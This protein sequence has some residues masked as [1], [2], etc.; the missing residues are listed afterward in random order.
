MPAWLA[1]RFHAL[2]AFAF[3]FAALTSPHHPTQAYK[4]ATNQIV[5][6]ADDTVPR[7]LTASTQLD[8][9]TIAGTARPA[10]RA[11]P[12]SPLESPRVPFSRRPRTSVPASPLLNPGHTAKPGP[13]FRC[14]TRHF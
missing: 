8:Y 9:D 13:L 7:W 10:Q 2:A 6:F 1:W 4:K 5:V 11:P 14:G 3:A 12:S